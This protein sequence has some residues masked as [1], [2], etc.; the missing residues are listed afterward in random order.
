MF[1][2][3]NRVAVFTDETYST[4]RPS[5]YVLNSPVFKYELNLLNRHASTDAVAYKTVCESAQSENL[6]INIDIKWPNTFVNSEPIA[7]STASRTSTTSSTLRTGTKAEIFSKK[8]ASPSSFTSVKPPKKLS[9]SSKPSLQHGEA[10]QII[11]NK[12]IFFNLIAVT[13]DCKTKF[14]QLQDDIKANVCD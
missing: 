7:T 5:Y 12:S 11:D 13:T 1:L 4:T 3:L 9:M 10:P 6:P 8:T 2:I 14:L